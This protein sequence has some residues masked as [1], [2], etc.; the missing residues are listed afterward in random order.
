M[1]FAKLSGSLLVR[2]DAPPATSLPREVP[3]TA[4]AAVASIQN[5]SPSSLAPAPPPATGEG[6]KLLAHHL[7]ALKLPTFLERY[8]ALAR[9]CAAEGLDHSGFLLRL[10]ELELLSRER[11]LVERR[12]KGAGFPAV[13]SLDS[14]DFAAIPSLDKSLVLDLARCEFVARR[15]NIIAIGNSGTGKTH[16]A[17]GLGLAACQKGLSVGFATAAALAHELLETHSERQLSRLQR[18][19]AAYKLLII[20][21]LG[22]TPLSTAGAE[23]LFETFSR[24]DE[25]GST[26]VTSNLPFESWISVFGTERL[27]EALLD[28]LT[29]HA[30]VLELSGGSYR[31]KQEVAPDATSW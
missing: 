23:L 5:L 22:Y 14:F 18:R 6:A 28:R 7:K 20:D 29:Y 17:L 25:S 16:V 11:Q 8:D 15:E 9:Q 27:T 26:I 21:E 1:P 30:H 2:K 13:K 19:L 4:N 31:A 10:A 12:I 24:R 3:A